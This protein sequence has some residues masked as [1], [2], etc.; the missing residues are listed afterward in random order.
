MSFYFDVRAIKK[1][2]RQLPH[3]TEW[4]MKFPGDDPPAIVVKENLFKDRQ[5][6][7]HTEKATKANS[8]VRCQICDQHYTCNCGTAQ[9][10]ICRHIH[11]VVRLELSRT[12]TPE[13]RFEYLRS[14]ISRDE[15]LDESKFLECLVRSPLGPV[16]HRAGELVRQFSFSVE[17]LFFPASENVEL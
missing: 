13:Q 17:T 15:S 9:F 1:Q 8:C 3:A 4:H 11:A 10:T 5:C 16:H 7:C 6:Y 14:L 2:E 12:E